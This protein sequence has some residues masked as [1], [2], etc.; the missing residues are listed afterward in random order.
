[1]ASHSA[2]ESQKRIQG[3]LCDHCPTIWLQRLMQDVEGYLLPLIYYLP[4]RR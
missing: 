4:L 3:N 2:A 1:M